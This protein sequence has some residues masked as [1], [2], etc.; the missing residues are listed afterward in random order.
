MYHYKAIQNNESLQEYADDVQ[1][2]V[3]MQTN[4]VSSLRSKIAI[5]EREMFT[6]AQQG[7]ELDV[8]ERRK[9]AEVIKKLVE[10][11]LVCQDK[12]KEFEEEVK[13]VNLI[14]NQLSI[15]VK[16]EMAHV[17]NTKTK[18]VL[19]TVL[20]RLKDSVGTMITGTK[21]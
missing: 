1:K 6:I 2:W 16:D 19:S 12:L 13:P 5:L 20:D 4:K 21:E 3:G 7:E 9:N 14:F 10:T 18:K 11:I 15:I 8:A 17:E